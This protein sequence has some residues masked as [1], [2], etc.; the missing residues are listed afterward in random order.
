MYSSSD[1]ISA[2]FVHETIEEY[3]NSEQ[4]CNTVIQTN[5]NSLNLNG[6]EYIVVNM[7][8]E[9]F[10]REKEGVDMEKITWTNA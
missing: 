2:R 10:V 5:H 9:D 7:S 3:N 8:Y 1:K 4:R 6:G